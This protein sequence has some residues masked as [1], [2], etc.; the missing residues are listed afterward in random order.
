MSEA[1]V[2]LPENRH[3]A[4]ALARK[5]SVELNTLIYIKRSLGVLV[6]FALAQGVPASALAELTGDEIREA[7][8]QPSGK[9]YATPEEGLAM[10]LHE[11]AGCAEVEEA[12]ALYRKPKPVTASAITDRIRSGDMIAYKTGASQYRVPRWQ[13]RPEGGLLRGLS[14]VLKKLRASDPSYNQ[15]TPFTF[16]LQPHPLTGER[17][18]LEVLREG[19]VALA[20]R[21]A[22][23]EEE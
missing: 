10:L 19:D 15:L 3:S 12:A 18:P 13:F 17:T 16:F 22:Q 9:A 5:F 1:A 4:A 11:E 20:L 8:E 7:I 21:A 6:E 23:S 14:V 2:E